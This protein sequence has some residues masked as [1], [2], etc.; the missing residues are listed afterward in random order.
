MLLI[1][2]FLSNKAYNSQFVYLVSYVCSA[3]LNAR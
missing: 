2:I 1:V 3:N